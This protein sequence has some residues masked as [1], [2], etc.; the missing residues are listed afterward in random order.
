[1]SHVSQQYP[2]SQK[3]RKWRLSQENSRN[4]EIKKNANV[5]RDAWRSQS[6]D[7]STLM[8]PDC[9]AMWSSPCPGPC[10]GGGHEVA[11]QEIGS[12]QLEE[13]LSYITIF[14]FL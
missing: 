4:K 5:P 9:I 6:Q 14:L 1:M 12:E 7:R 8:P 13:Y 2:V 3:W 10:P 11:P